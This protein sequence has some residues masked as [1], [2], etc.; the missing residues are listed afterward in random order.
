MFSFLRMHQENIF[1]PFFRSTLLIVNQILRKCMNI[2]VSL[3]NL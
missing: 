1:Q 3:V 2:S